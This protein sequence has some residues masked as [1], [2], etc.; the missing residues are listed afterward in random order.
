MGRS[1]WI[2]PSEKEELGLVLGHLTD[3]EH[4]LPGNT[5]MH[6][7]F[8]GGIWLFLWWDC[9]AGVVWNVAGEGRRLMFVDS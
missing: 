1:G 3:S 9:I 2:V 5:Y 6:R 8:F 4:R 7:L